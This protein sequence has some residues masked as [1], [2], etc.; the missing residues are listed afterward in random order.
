MHR[1]QRWK[2][3]PL[4]AWACLAC[5]NLSYACPPWAVQM[6]LDISRMSGRL[7]A[8]YLGLPGTRLPRRDPET[9][10]RS[11]QVSQRLGAELLHHVVAMHLHGDIADADLGGGLL[12]HQAGADQLHDLLLTRTERVEAG[13]QVLGFPF[14]LAPSAIALDGHSDRVQEILL[15]D[16]L[17]E[18]LDR[19]GLHGLDAHRDVAVAGDEDDGRVNVGL[20]QLSLKVE[21]AQLRH[22]DIEYETTGIVRKLAA[23]QFRW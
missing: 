16:R 19:S 11:H 20:G 21:A 10:G 2:L 15:P 17:G 22:S 14:V 1:R 18:E 7:S 5:D 6:H 13:T 8:R 4:P 9:A 23:Q 3:S 12:V